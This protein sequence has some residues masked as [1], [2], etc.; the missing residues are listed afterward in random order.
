MK[1]DHILSY[2]Y[3]KTKKTEKMFAH[4]SVTVYTSHGFENDY[5]GHTAYKHRK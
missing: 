5:V 4:L 2:Y 1:I 3:Y